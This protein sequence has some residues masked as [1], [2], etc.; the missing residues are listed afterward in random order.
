MWWVRTF[1]NGAHFLTAAGLGILVGVAFARRYEPLVE[2][3]GTQIFLSYSTENEEAA[4]SLAQAL[5]AAGVKVFYAP[6]SIRTSQS[7]PKR[8]EE[9]IEACRVGVLLWS[10]AA[11]RSAWVTKER[12][13]L[14][15][16]NVEQRVPLQVVRLEDREVP[17]ALK[18]LHRVDACA[19]WR[20]EEIAAAILRDTGVE[21]ALAREGPAS[22]DTPS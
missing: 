2:P 1:A 5:T 21:E 6:E 12:S 4:A 9:A 13:M 22:P 14:T 7:F 16:R 19:E 18:D 15:L 17:L 3:E 8:I 11:E 10:E 20:P